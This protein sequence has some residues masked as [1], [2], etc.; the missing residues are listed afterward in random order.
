MSLSIKAGNFLFRNFYFLYR[1]LYYAF[2]RRQDRFEI[3]LL[4]KYIE[5]GMVIADIGANIGFYAGILSRLA[6]PQGKVHCF[7]PDAIN[8]R[9]LQK[10]V[11]G[12]NN[13]SI[14]QKAVGPKTGV[15]KIYTSPNLNVD[16][17]T[18]EPESYESVFEVS[19][20]SLDDY[21]SA[22]NHKVDFIKMD[23]QGF[24]M[25]AIKGMQKVLEKNPGL[26]MI[27]EF[28][29]Y[30]VRKA[31]SSV[32]QY[33]DRL[34][35][36]DFQLSLLTEN[37]LEHLSRERVLQMQDLGEEHYFNILAIR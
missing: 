3:S 19:A 5:P 18:Y 9:R 6:G 27:S 1:P 29:P 17:R 31:G 21:L 32:L 23:I 4:E 25:E 35:E 13:V 11:S 26:R 28:W 20:V 22:F 33:F 8:F 14:H 37:G 16:H 2:K 30:G 34:R 7:E 10:T 24:E 15:I 12:L 36:L